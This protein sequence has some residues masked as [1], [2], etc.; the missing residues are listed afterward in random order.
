[1]IGDRIRMLRRNAG[2]TQIALG[3]DLDVSAT[4]VVL[5][6]TGKRT[7]DGEIVKKLA[8]LFNVTTDW[9]LFGDENNLQVSL[10]K[11]ENTITMLGR[12]GAMKTYIVDDAKFKEFLAHVEELSKDE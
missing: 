5:W 8:K 4:A 9:L 1:M 3:M 7:P 10:P 2:M 6:E 11:T 12:K